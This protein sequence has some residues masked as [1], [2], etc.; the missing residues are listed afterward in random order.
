MMAM[1]DSRDPLHRKRKASVPIQECAIVTVA[2]DRE[3]I[4]W[5]YATMK[6]EREPDALTE[7]KANPSRQT[8]RG[9]DWLIILVAD[10]QLGSGAVP[11]FVFL[12]P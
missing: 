1:G 11:H 6:K 10:V 2:R 9:L 12:L 5:W 7:S 3:S 8:L 4:G